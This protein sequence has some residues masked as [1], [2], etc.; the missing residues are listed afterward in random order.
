MTG[1]T[2]T[3]C[4]GATEPPQEPTWS[5]I[6]GREPAAASLLIRRTSSSLRGRGSTTEAPTGLV[7]SSCGAAT[8]RAV[9]RSWSA[10]STPREIRW[11]ARWRRREGGSSSLRTTACMG[12]SCG[13]PTGRRPSS[14]VMRFPARRGP[15]VPVPL[16]LRICLSVWMTVSCTR[17]PASIRVGNRGSRT[18]PRAARSCSPTSTSSLKARPSSGFR[19]EATPCCSVPTA[20]TLGRNS[21]TRTVLKGAPR[22]WRT[23]CQGLSPP[24]RSPISRRATARPS[25][26]PAHQRPVSRSG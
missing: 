3:S 16:R 5:K 17:G 14:Y 21:G 8:V 23:L 1:C 13:G 11:Q 20:V 19:I 25:F 12:S 4:G 2:D 9:V 15:S 10:T 24:A 18:A 22:C 6:A 7:D 26:A